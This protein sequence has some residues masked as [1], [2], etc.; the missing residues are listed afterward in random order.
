MIEAEPCAAGGAARR[1]YDWLLLIWP[2]R[3]ALVA[4]SAP[5]PTIASGPGLLS[6]G[7]SAERSTGS[8]PRPAIGGHRATPYERGGPAVTDPAPGFDLR[9]GP[10][11][12]LP[13]SGLWS[14]RAARSGQPHP[15]RSAATGSV[16]DLRATATAGEQDERSSDEQQQAGDGGLVDGEAGVGKRWPLRRGWRRWRFDGWSRDVD[17]D[18]RR[19]RRVVAV[20]YHLHG[21]GDGAGRVESDAQEKCCRSAGHHR[22]DRPAPA[23][24]RVFAREASGSQHGRG[25]RQCFGDGD[26]C[27]DVELPCCA[28]VMV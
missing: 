18:V 23:P 1:E 14:D 17:I 10:S 20:F 28:T 16:G 22:T 2:P 4:G 11:G 26:R 13:G 7:R 12:D 24:G 27:A 25:G 3:L 15:Q 5:S 6:E 21:V 9:V 19:C 8:R